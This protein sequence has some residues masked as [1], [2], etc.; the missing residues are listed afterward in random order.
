VRYG[1]GPACTSIPLITAP[2][3]RRRRRQ[4]VLK[5][6][7]TKILAIL[8]IISLGAVVSAALG[9][10]A[11]SR[12]NDLSQRSAVLADL[13]LFTD[14]INGHVLGVVMDARG[15]YMSKDAAAA[16]PFATADAVDS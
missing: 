7:R 5:S 10:W 13:T 15:V 9:L 16:E 12:T 6:I 2:F 8:A 11:L 14:R 3:M 1:I 4:M